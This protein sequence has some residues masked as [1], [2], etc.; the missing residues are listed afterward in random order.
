MARKISIG[1]RRLAVGQLISA[2][3]GALAVVGIIAAV[4]ILQRANAI[5]KAEAWMPPGAPC[6]VSSPAALLASGNRVEHVSVYDNIRF[7][8]RS[9]FV[10]CNEVAS[11]GGRGAGL[12]SVCQFNNPTVLQVT[13]RRGDFF[14]FPRSKPATVSV[15][16][17]TP[18]CVLA[19]TQKLE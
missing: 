15:E 2:G 16:D 11:D 5:A 19:A 14:Y 6:P 9:G 8:R 3:V 10:T 1:G 17:D 12:V 7:G 18:R 13:T 4:L